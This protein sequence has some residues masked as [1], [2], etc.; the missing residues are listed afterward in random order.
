MF[1]KRITRS[2]QGA[3]QRL[4]RVPKGRALKDECREGRR[5]GIPGREHSL[6]NALARVRVWGTAAECGA[7]WSGWNME[8]LKMRRSGGWSRLRSNHEKLSMSG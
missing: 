7:A 1:G 5:D 3:Q 2:V 8:Y 4:D 6:S